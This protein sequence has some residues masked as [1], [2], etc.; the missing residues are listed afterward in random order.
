MS[1]T[2]APA[3]PLSVRPHRRKK[4]KTSS[5]SSRKERWLPC[6][7]NYEV[8]NLGRVR[9]VTSNCGTQ[10]GR[11]L[12]PQLGDRDY[13]NVQL[14][15][16]SAGVWRKVHRLVL[17][18]FRGARPKGYVSCHLNEDKQDNRLVN[19]DYRT[20]KENLRRSINAGTPWPQLF[21]KG[22]NGGYKVGKRLNWAKV[23]KIRDLARRGVSHN[24]LA[25]K[26]NCSKAAI[27]H[28]VAGR[29]WRRSDGL[30]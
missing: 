27:G 4:R 30:T 14:W 20:Q 9:R 12:R 29:R 1:G 23:E 22:E 18:A 24:S 3:V 26:F 17:N 8:S 19:L 13:L 11:I 16:N 7:P 10:V 6:H 25:K 21:K 28:V 2:Q 15:E 5:K